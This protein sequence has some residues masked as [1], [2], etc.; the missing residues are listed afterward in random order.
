ML[1]FAVLGILLGLDTARAG[2]DVEGYVSMGAHAGWVEFAD[3][4]WYGSG[5]DLEVRQIFQPLV[6]RGVSLDMAV[7]TSDR[8]WVRSL[9]KRTASEDLRR[10]RKFALM[11]G[12]DHVGLAWQRDRLPG[13]NAVGIYNDDDGLRVL[14]PHEGAAELKIE[15]LGAYWLFDSGIKAGLQRMTF[16][17]PL[18]VPLYDADD[19]TA[20]ATIDPTYGL[21]SWSAFWSLEMTELMVTGHENAFGFPLFGNPQATIT[22]DLKM[23]AGFGGT[24]MSDQ[25]YEQVKDATGRSIEYAGQ[26]FYHHELEFRPMFAFERFHNPPAVLAFGYSGAQ[27]L[28]VPMGDP[29]AVDVSG[30]TLTAE[31]S[32]FVYDVEQLIPHGPFVQLSVGL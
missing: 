27:R 31:D 16:R 25:A 26:A 11:G 20:Y 32:M 12:F 13:W 4:F 14:F 29:S 21:T 17:G 7:G 10:L 2:S 8:W 18:L 9:I 6:M 23:A 5:G 22:F 28:L 15:T 3:E 19:R 30:N 1:S 24:H